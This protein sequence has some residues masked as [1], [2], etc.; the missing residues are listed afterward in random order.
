MRD[1]LERTTAELSSKREEYRQ[2]ESQQLFVREQHQTLDLDL[3]RLREPRLLEEIDLLRSQIPVL[4]SVRDRILGTTGPLDGC[5][6]QDITEKLQTKLGD[7][8]KTL[9]TLRESIQDYTN[10]LS[11]KIPT[12]PI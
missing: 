10:A 8:R 12:V 2:L 9:D 1:P 7:A 5:V 11:Q 3:S 4:E 6:S